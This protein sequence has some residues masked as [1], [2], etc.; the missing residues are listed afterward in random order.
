MN[1]NIYWI[2]HAESLSNT[3]ELNSQIKDP[4]LTTKGIIECENLKKKLI[5][6]KILNSID[7]IVVSPLTRTLETSYEIFHSSAYNIPI[8]SL[9][10]IREQMDKPCHNRNVIINKKKKYPYINFSYMPNNDI[11]YNKSR[12][13]EK[14]EQ[15]ITR[16][17]WFI[18]WL[19]NCKEKNIAVIT[20]G[21]FLYPMFNDVLKNVL[22]KTFF[23]NCEIRLQYLY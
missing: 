3:S 4:K 8:I 2:R 21:N 1:K 13:N 10:E 9:D 15:V 22:N 20:H 11:M 6:E 19:K 14:K 17:K 12:G 7:L 5:N 18:R 16:C 23:T